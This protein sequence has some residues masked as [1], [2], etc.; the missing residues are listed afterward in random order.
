MTE[1]VPVPVPAPVQELEQAWEFV[2]V[3]KW[4]LA[5]GSFDSRYHRNP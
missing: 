2:A 1:Q 4:N 3:A 5:P